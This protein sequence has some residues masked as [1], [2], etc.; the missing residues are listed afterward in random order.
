MSDAKL[1][2]D[3]AENARKKADDELQAA[4]KAATESEK[5]IRAIAFSAD[6]QTVATAGEDMA[7][8]TWSAESGLA[9]DVIRDNKSPVA[10][11]AYAPG[12]ELISLTQDRSAVAW[13]L[14]FAWKLEKIIGSPD[15]KSPLIDRVESLAFSPD[16]QFLAIGG[17]EPSR[18]GEIKLWD[19]RSDQFA[20]DFANIHSDAVLSLEFSAD[21]KFLASGAADKMARVIDLASG[22]VARSFEGHTHHVLGISWSLDGR[23][24]AT[25]GADSVVKT[26]NVTT[27]DRRKNIE[28]YDKEVTSVHFLGAAEQ[29][30]TSSGDNKVRI[31]TADGKEIRALPDVVDFVQA[32]AATA[33]GKLI[34]AGGQDSVLRLWNAADGKAAAAF[35]PGRK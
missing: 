13:D 29:V 3:A 33:D 34:V 32:A 10:A 5:P 8:H 27:G 16:G 28:G 30:V 23:T 7:I 14:T 24:L 4:R 21:G 12:G 9:I 2:V 15:G 25:A 26:W 11:L 6:G 20:R 35:P 31:V 17:G 1:A 18:G 19:I 22:K